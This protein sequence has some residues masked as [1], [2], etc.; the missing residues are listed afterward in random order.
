MLINLR[1]VRICS[2]LLNVQW[3]SQRIPAHRQSRGL[4]TP[5]CC[6]QGHKNWCNARASEDWSCNL[7]IVEVIGHVELIICERC[8]C[9]QTVTVLISW[10]HCRVFWPSNVIGEVEEDR[11]QEVVEKDEDWEQGRENNNERSCD[12]VDD[13]QMK[14]MRTKDTVSHNVVCTQGWKCGEKVS[15]EVCLHLPSVTV[16][17]YRL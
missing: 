11:N 1:Q 15:C 17:R 12:I 5:C 2:S 6:R 16:E 9:G 13:M 8:N 10:Y 7:Y 4:G 3:W 14:C